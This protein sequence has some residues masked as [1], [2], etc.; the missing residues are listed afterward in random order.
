MASKI[1]YE[2]NDAHLVSLVSEN[3]DDA[4]DYLYQKYSPMIHKEINR[5]RSQAVALGIEIADLTQEAMLA[6]GNAI[7]NFNEDENVKFITFAT[8]CVRRKLLNFL[9]KY[10]T[11]KNLLM[12]Y[13][14]ALDSRFNNSENTI[15][16]SLKDK[17]GNEP[18]NKM[19]T[20][21]SLDEVSQLMLQKLSERER[22]TLLLNLQ[23]KSIDEIARDLDL[24]PKQ[25]YNL[26]YRGPKKLK[27][28]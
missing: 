22:Q 5:V 10:S 12:N 20:T 28:E 6:F 9:T 1:D 24:K 13:A 14:I 17:G 25:V 3:N 4:V 11:N 8:L 21:E 23:G 16:E 18:L 27:A 2:I 15:I 7:N 26:L 19:I